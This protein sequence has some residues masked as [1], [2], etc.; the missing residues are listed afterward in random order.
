MLMDVNNGARVVEVKSSP[1]WRRVNCAS[2]ESRRRRNGGF[3]ESETFE[4]LVVEI[5]GRWTMG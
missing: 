1:G 2:I 4:A 5:Q 3:E